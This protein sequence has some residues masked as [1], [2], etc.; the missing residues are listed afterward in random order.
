MAIDQSILSDVGT[1]AAHA[2]SFRA[3][4]SA[5]VRSPGLV[6][7]GDLAVTGDPVAMAVNIDTGCAF[8]EYDPGQY[9]E[10]FNV[11]APEQRALATATGNRMDL[12]Y[13]GVQSQEFGNGSNHK[14]LYVVRGAN[15][16]TT[17]PMTDPTMLSM[18]AVLL[19]A[20]V[21][22]PSGATKGSQC[23]ITM[24]ADTIAPVRDGGYKP[25]DLAGVGA[26]YCQMT[27]TATQSLPTAT[28]NGS[29]F[30]TTAWSQVNWTTVTSDVSDADANS[31]PDVINNRMLVPVSDYYSGMVTVSF[32]ASIPPSGMRGLRV[33]TLGGGLVGQTIVPA[34]A[35]GFLPARLTCSYETP[36]NGGDHLIAEVL[37]TQGSTLTLPAAGGYNTTIW[38]QQRGAK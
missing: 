36:L 20:K 35:F 6:S 27:R 18:A 38:A 33:R 17:P 29:T 31:M 1:A 25:T 5:F 19:I 2:R 7:A 11:D 16:S 22:V 10:S 23:T 8:C 9:F 21:Q 26:N 12:V 37:Q 34:D 13:A 32:P 4:A 14:D 28:I 30:D 15:G 24:L 3:L